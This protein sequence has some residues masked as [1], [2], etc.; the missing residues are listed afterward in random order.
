M[1]RVIFLKQ[2]NTV[3]TWLPLSEV[4]SGIWNEFS[5]GLSMG[6]VELTYT[7]LSNDRMP[8]FKLPIAFNG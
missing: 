7:G 1:E 4:H 3:S 5:G 2:P 6:K 8:S